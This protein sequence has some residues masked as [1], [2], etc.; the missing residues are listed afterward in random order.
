MSRKEQ[1]DE[2]QKAAQKSNN[3]REHLDVGNATRR[4]GGASME[5]RKD[6]CRGQTNGQGEGGKA[7]GEEKPRMTRVEQTGSGVEESEKREG[8]R[9]RRAVRRKQREQW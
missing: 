1:K 7:E 8:R 9:A 5:K 4:R 3:E 2:D 6:R